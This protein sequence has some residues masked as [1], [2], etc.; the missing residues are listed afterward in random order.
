MSK[1]STPANPFLK[2]Q[3]QWSNAES[4]L[5]NQDKRLKS[6]IIGYLPNDV[7]TSVI[8]YKTAKEMWTELC[9]AYEGP[10]DT[11]DTI[12]ATL[13]LKFNAFK[14]LESEKVNAN[15]SIKNDS[16]TALYGKYHYEKGLI[17][18]IYAAETQKFTIQA[19]SS[20]ALIS[21][22]HF[23]DS[24]SD[25]EEE[26]ITNNEFMADMNAK[27]H[28]RDLLANQKRFYKRFVLEIKK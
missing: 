24:D 18:D 25:V 1:L 12:I 11:R 14:A 19:S 7:M 4:R 10:S 27:Y 17:D 23:Q 6:T 26:N 5:A 8:K 3:N 28:E 20:K 22:N 13:R 16:L 2:R 9:L 15:N 21:N